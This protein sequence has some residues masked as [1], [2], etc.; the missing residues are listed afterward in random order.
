MTFL[1]LKPNH[2][3]GKAENLKTDQHCKC[4]KKTPLAQPRMHP[5]PP[6]VKNECESTLPGHPSELSMPLQAT[7]SSF[8]ASTET[9]K[10]FFALSLSSISTIRSTPPAP[11]TT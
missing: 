1:R 6:H 9:S 3:P 5:N 7:S 2:Q 8:T 4:A 10:F 11:I